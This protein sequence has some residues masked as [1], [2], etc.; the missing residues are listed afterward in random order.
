MLRPLSLRWS[1]LFAVVVLLLSSCS[2]SADDSAATTLAATTTTTTTTTAIEGSPVPLPNGD[3]ETGDFSSWSIESWGHGDWYIYEDGTT[4]PDPSAT[5]TFVPFQAPD[6][7]QGRYAAVTDTDYSG[8]HI[9]YRDIEIAGPWTLHA[10]VFY[11]NPIG[12][13]YEQ[14]DFGDFDGEAWL[15]G[16]GVTH[17]Q[18]RIDL[19]DPRAPIYSTEVDDVLATM[20]WTRDGDPSSLEPTPMSIDLSPWEGQTIRLHVVQVDNKAALRAGIDDVRIMSTD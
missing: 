19:V 1:V 16:S 8:V 2:G 3:F 20:F 14:P 18:Y 15:A 9:L 11:E 6:P 5:D 7:P 10:I 17:Q 4:P 13:I 12:T